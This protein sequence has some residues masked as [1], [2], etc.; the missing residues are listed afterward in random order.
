MLLTL[1]ISHAYAFSSLQS[2]EKL[3]FQTIIS[4]NT[5]LRPLDLSGKFPFNILMR[6]YKPDQ[7]TL[8]LSS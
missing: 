7:P 6:M 1:S 3:I 2:R 4:D 8:K 5:V